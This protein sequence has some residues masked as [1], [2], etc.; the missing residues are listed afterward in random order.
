MAVPGA[1]RETAAGDEARDDSREKPQHDCAPVCHVRRFAAAGWETERDGRTVVA[2]ARGETRRLAVGRLPPDAKA[3]TMVSVPSRT[4][5]LL[6]RFAG[7]PTALAAGTGRSGDGSVD[8]ATLHER[9]LY[10]VDRDRAARLYRAHFG[11]EFD[12]GPGR[13]GLEPVGRTVLA[14]LVVAALVGSAAAAFALSAGTDAADTGADV[15]GRSDTGGGTAEPVAAG[16]P[17]EDRPTVV[18][19]SEVE[20]PDGLLRAHRRATDGV[21]VEMRAQFR[22]PRFLM[23]FDTR[24]SGYDPKDEVTFTV[25]A[26]SP[27]SYHVVRRINFSGNDLTSVDARYERYADGATEHRRLEEDGAVEYDRW[28]LSSVRGGP[29]TI[30]SW[31]RLLV[32]RYMNTTDRR[33]EVVQA[34]LITRYRVVATGEPRILD[35]A[36]RDY[37]AVATVRP[38]GLITALRV[39][40]VHP[41]TGTPVDVRL[42]YNTRAVA[43]EPPDWYSERTDE[44]RGGPTPASWN[45]DG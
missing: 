44:A 35:H 25:R 42:R 4:A 8:V 1:A 18:S 15:E 12:T 16:T 28:S 2:T 9:L 24:R 31:S 45:G 29:E 6:G 11:T 5:A 41:G 34:G 22:G 32:E 19:P 23:G 37:R 27:T 20:D 38:D 3:D 40:Y 33:V 13:D 30:D 43:V 21:P 10:A 36:T 17:D 26:E 39:T 7:R 14:V